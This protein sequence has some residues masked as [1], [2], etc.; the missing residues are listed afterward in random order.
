MKFFTGNMRVKWGRMSSMSKGI[1]NIVY[2]Q[3]ARSISGRIFLDHIYPYRYKF[4]LAAFFMLVAA[5]ANGAIPFVLKNV[6][7][8]IFIQGNREL[9]FIVSF[10]V[11]VAF[12]VRGL[13]TFGETF[14]MSSLGQR[15]ICDLQNRLFS[16]LM[17]CDLA[18]FNAHQSGELIS[19]FTNDITLLRFSVSNAVVGIGR[20]AITLI[21]MVSIMFYRDWFL[22]TLAFFLLPTLILP[23]SKLSRR[24]RKVTY[25]T[26]G[27]FGKITGQ[28]SQLFQGI[29]VVKSYGMEQYEIGRIQAATERVYTLIVKA[30]RIRA[31]SS[32]IV[33]ALGGLSSMMIVLYGG[34]QVIQ[35]TRTAGEFISFAAAMLLCYEPIKRLGSLNS[36]LQEG[37]SAASRVFEI[38]D[39]PSFIIDHPQAKKLDKVQGVI[40]FDQVSFRYNDDVEALKD[41]SFTVPQG[42]T[43]ALVGASGSGKSTIINLI[44]RFYDV[45]G[46][47]ITIDS[48]SVK[49]VT[50][51]SLRHHVGLVSQEVML[52]DDT[53]YNN[54]AYGRMDASAEEIYQAA[55]LAAA[56]HFIQE[57]PQGYETM[58]GE[59]GVALSGGQRQRIAIARAMLKNA[60]ILLLDEATSAL[61]THSERLV[62][63]ALD[64]LMQGKT[65]IIV[66]HRL[67]TIVG[68]DQI[69]VLD[70][71]QIVESG[72][73]E[74]LIK[75]Q[76]LYAALWQAQS[77]A[78]DTSTEPL[79]V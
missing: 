7:D 74:T 35:Q 9:L 33:E 63:E 60:P 78:T 30:A 19:R 10:S 16:H 72:N 29:R 31:T 61:D 42:G 65:T 64:T 79:K 11:F 76:G 5:L 75:K 8:D 34:W 17:T 47:D 36:N 14:M 52:F 77:S 20:D 73:H 38:L 57:L 50:L 68:A 2:D 13:A 66:A 26:Q 3:K 41:I 70:K 67:S 12:T 22:A 54:I 71:G 51:S 18:F 58:V 25:N 56:D 43:V 44:P 15:I 59:N 49:S 32:P 69:Y 62:Q 39:M 55:Q 28:L 1:Q 48:Q 46:G 40:S 27:A 4:L 23:L 24:M 21:V 37:L 6:F 45:T 53:I